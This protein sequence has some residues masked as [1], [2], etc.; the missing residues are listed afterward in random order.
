MAYAKAALQSLSVRLLL[1]LLAIL[2][3]AFG[4]YAVLTLQSAQEQFVAIAGAEATRFSTLILRATHD[5]M[6]NGGQRDVQRAIDALTT[7]GTVSTIRLY[8]NDGRIAQSA[9]QSEVGSFVGLR[10]E[11]CLSCHLEGRATRPRQKEIVLWAKQPPIL[12]HLSVIPNGERCSGCHPAASAQPILGVLDVEL[13]MEPLRDAL[14][15]AR[16]RTLWTMSALLL[17]TGVVSVGLVQR[18][19]HRPVRRLYEGT[20]QLAH[21]DL[22]TRIEV[23]G[24]DEL[25]ALAASFN[26]MAAELQGAR[27]ELTRWSQRLEEKVVDK[28]EEL[29]QT[30]RQVLQAERMA[31]LGKLAATVAHELNNPLSGILGCARVVDRELESQPLPNAV[32]AELREYLRLIAQECSRCGTI[33]QN[34]LLFARHSV[35]SEMAPVDLRQVIERSLLLVRHRLQVDDVALETQLCDADCNIVGNAGELEQAVVALLVNAF[36]A[37]EATGDRGCLTVRLTGEPEWVQIEVGDTGVGIHPEVL[38]H[39]FEPFFSTKHQESGVGLGLAVVYGIVQRHGG[40]IEVAS[41]PGAGTTFTMRLPRHP[42]AAAAA[43]E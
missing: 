3:L 9:V 11:P 42:E 10:Q 29:R 25:T 26:R 17:F 6:L 4:V 38:P 37:V 40:T 8:T 2:A 36:E 14:V 33:V 39:I 43:Q 12:R 16:R 21:G 20:E 15:A 35:T 5:R 34:L 27:E 23:S 13:S 1:P 32:A 22:S 31:S 24:N 30:Q 18:L 7:E 41:S 28:T 19:V